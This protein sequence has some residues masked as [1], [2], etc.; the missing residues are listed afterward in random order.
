LSPARILIGTAAWNEGE[1]IERQTGRI[2][3]F[4]KSR[5]GQEQTE[6]IYLL[7]DDGSVDGVPQK[8]AAIPGVNLIRHEQN[9]GAGVSV[10][11]IYRFAR[12]KK[13]EIA[14]TIAGNGKDDPQEIP[15]LTAPILTQ[16]FDFVQGSRYLA[17]APFGS[18]PA[19][20]FFATK[21]LHPLLFSFFAGKKFTDTTNGFRAVKTS[22]LD[23][24]RIG[25]DQPWLD[26]YELEPYVF[27]QAAKLGYRVCEA[28]V[29]KVYPGAATGYTKMVP[30]KD[31]WSILRPL[32]LLGL[33]LRK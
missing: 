11:E 25:L 16:G 20:R 28:P 5:A 26:R 9:Q 24:K 15:R 22:V 14:V 12:E 21:Y 7:I 10:R 4:I 18:M 32:F 33:G 23:D 17:P 19:Y 2:L 8:L 3:D 31:W 29:S 27:F 6:Y 30:I 13:C 1:K